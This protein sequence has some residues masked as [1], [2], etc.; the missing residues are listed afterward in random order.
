VADYR[1][2][3]GLPPNA[4]IVASNDPDQCFNE[5][6]TSVGALARRIGQR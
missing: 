5:L 1:G 3:W 4:R 2:L 6:I